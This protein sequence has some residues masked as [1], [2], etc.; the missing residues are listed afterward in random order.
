M[1]VEDWLTGLLASLKIQ[2]EVF[3]LKITERI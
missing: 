2:A 3:L 1:V